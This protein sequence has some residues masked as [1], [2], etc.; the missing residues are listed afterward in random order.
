[1]SFSD[2]VNIYSQ[3]LSEAEFK[4]IQTFMLESLGIKLSPIKIVMVNSRLIKE[5][6]NY[7]F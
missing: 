6:W 1:M 4:R 2:A 3:Q 5:Y 7:E